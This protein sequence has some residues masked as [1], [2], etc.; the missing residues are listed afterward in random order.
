MKT[1]GHMSEEIEK[2]QQELD[3]LK[4]KQLERQRQE[5][6][7]TMLGRSAYSRNQEQALRNIQPKVPVTDALGSLAPFL[8][9][10]PPHFF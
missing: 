2:K 10:K 3:A 1:V 4:D 8:R 6:E 5:Q 7:L 9:G